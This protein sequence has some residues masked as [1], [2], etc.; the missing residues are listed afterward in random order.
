MA[1]NK[2]VKGIVVKYNGKDIVVTK[3]LMQTVMGFVLVLLSFILSGFFAF[4]SVGFDASR[5][6]TG[7]FWLSYFITLGTMYICFFGVYTIREGRNKRQPK[8]VIN[9][10]ARRDFRNSIIAN[11]KLESCENWLKI[12]NYACRVE[13]HKDNLTEM[14]RKLKVRQKPDESLDT[15]SFRYR[16][17]LK[18]YNNYIAKKEYIKKQL[19][20]ANIHSDIVKALKNGDIQAVNALRAKLTDADS[21]KRARIIWREIYFNDLF[22]SSM[23]H[24]SKSIFYNK[25]SA[26]WDNIKLALIMSICGTMITTSMILSGNEVNIYTVLTILSNIIMLACYS[27]MAMRV[28]DNVVF[29]VI[30]PADENKLLICNQFK[31]DDERS[32]DKWLDIEEIEEEDKETIVTDSPQ[33]EVANEES[34]I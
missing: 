18:K 10:T 8:I 27:V 16:H 2:E 12:Y 25:A 22:N 4:V 11:R 26:I 32:S 9:N 33:K 23:R 13:I 6:V 24:D 34:N 15:D 14:Y 19:E 1:R 17:R 29:E 28:A 20:F 3:D 30:Y 21:F 7:S 31:E 5:L